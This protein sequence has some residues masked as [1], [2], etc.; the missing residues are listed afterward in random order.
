[1]QPGE[2]DRD[3]AGAADAHQRLL[4]HLDAAP[5]TDPRAPSLLPDW[6]IGHV[7][8]HLARNADSF[9]RMLDGL[10]QYER[11]AEGR[12]ADI[13]AGSRRG[14]DELVD[15]VRRS[16]WRLETRWSTGVDWSARAPTVAGEVALAEVPSRRW[17]ETEVHHADLGLGYTFDD[18]PDQYVR[19]ELRRMEMLWRARRPMG[20]TS[21]PPEAVA[22]PA[23]RRLAWLLG[24]A[25]IDGLPPAGIY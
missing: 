16:I 3:V 13:E 8:T 12:A 20:L 25:S 14:F 10:P 17:R 7:L 1:M 15:D 18:L 11:G 23:A 4:A 9:V 6:S 2:I 5:D 19:L 24:R 21:L 22:E